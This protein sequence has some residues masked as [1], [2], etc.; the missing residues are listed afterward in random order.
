MSDRRMKYSIALFLAFSFVCVLSAGPKM[1]KPEL[2]KILYDTCKN[3]HGVDGEGNPAILA[4]GINGMPAWYI[5]ASIKKYQNGTRGAHPDDP[6]GLRMRPLSR[7]L[8]TDKEIEAVAN[9]I[10][11]LKPKA[12]PITV[13]GDVARGKTLYMTCLACH[14]PEGQGNPA[15]KAP[16]IK[17]LPD[18]YIVNQLQKYRN[19]QRA[20]NPKDIEGQQMKGMA[21]TLP[22]EQALSDVAA[23]ISTFN[24]SSATAAKT[25][26]AHH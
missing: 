26:A 16:P 8:K 24:K 9:Y 5:I 20:S 2:G 3:C 18:W 22:D 14:G 23:Y 12:N 15:L 21:M 17:L 7:H 6:A 11:H 25:E 19:G 10:E 1:K 13:H 4:P